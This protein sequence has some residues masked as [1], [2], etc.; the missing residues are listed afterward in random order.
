MQYYKNLLCIETS[1]LFKLWEFQEKTTLE[2]DASQNE[3]KF[4]FSMQ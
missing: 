1:R 4:A 3:F 2:T